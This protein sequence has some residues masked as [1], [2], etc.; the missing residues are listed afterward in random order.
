[1]FECFEFIVEL[2]C[3]CISTAVINKICD[4]IFVSFNDLG[5]DFT[6]I[7]V[8][9]CRCNLVHHIGIKSETLLNPWL[10]RS[11][12]VEVSIFKHLLY[13]AD[14]SLTDVHFLFQ[15][16]HLHIK[17]SLIASRSL[18]HHCWALSLPLL[19][20]RCL[21]HLLLQLS[22][23]ALRFLNWLVQLLINES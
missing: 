2:F 18:A 1:M 21:R 11:V 23:R 3:L 15:N 7:R 10:V 9:N 17:A 20:F 14:L 4:Y 6:N 13:R 19:R 16:K 8:I 12:I 5:N 22:L